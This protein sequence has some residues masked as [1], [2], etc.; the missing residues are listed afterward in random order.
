MNPMII[1][2][3]LFGAKAQEMLNKWQSMTPEQKQQEM[4]KVQN[5]TREQMNQYLQQFGFDI[6][7][8]QQNQNTN[9]DRKFNY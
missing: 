3:K 8:L 2:Q 7:S 9:T 1:M 4:M 5:M 6:N